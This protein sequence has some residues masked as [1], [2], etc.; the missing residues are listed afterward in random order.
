M[1]VHEMTKLSSSGDIFLENLKSE[2]DLKHAKKTG[3]MPQ[4]QF[5]EKS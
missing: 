4:D 5:V 3:C 1:S 2:T